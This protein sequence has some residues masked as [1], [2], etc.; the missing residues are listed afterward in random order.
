MQTSAMEREETWILSRC[1]Y[2]CL[3]DCILKTNT[4]INFNFDSFMDY[5][6]REPSTKADRDI[7]VD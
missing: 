6:Y 7:C 1:F 3:I 4:K 5:Y 2:M